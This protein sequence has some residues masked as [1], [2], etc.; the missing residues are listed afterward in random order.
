MYEQILIK[1]II[2]ILTLNTKVY[3]AY[4]GLFQCITHFC[5]GSIVVTSVCYAHQLIISQSLQKTLLT[6]TDIL[7]FSRIANAI[8]F[9]SYLETNP[10]VQYMLMNED[11]GRFS[12]AALRDKT[13][14]P[15]A[16]GPFPEAV[17]LTLCLHRLI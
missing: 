11:S 4:T 3:E 5:T 15:A 17:V 9:S 10:T 12:R 2:L 16:E 1:Y 8:S 6:R 13:H 7:P 14:W